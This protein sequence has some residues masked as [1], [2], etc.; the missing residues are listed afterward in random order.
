VAFATR[1]G[2]LRDAGLEANVVWTRQD[3]AVIVAESRLIRRPLM[4]NQNT[5][6]GCH[7]STARIRIRGYA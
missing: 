2:G 7:C 4:V 5:E 3:L 1:S 6:A